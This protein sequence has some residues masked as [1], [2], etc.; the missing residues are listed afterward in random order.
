[1]AT[2]DQVFD[3]YDLEFL[4]SDLR[5]DA[6][7]VLVAEGDDVASDDGLD[8]LNAA[9]IRRLNTPRGSIAVVIRDIG[10]LKVVNSDYGNPVYALVSE[11]R[12]PG[13]LQRVRLGVIDCLKDEDRIDVLDVQGFYRGPG[14]EGDMVVDI[15]YRVRATG[16]DV[17]LSTK[18][19][20]KG[21]EVL[22]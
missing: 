12:R 4:G 1:M 7:D 14:T 20:A 9:I 18:T 19:G 2:A 3:V 11:P 8:C 15:R 6:D 13:L 21:F 16:V 22:N 10:G 5:G 17:T